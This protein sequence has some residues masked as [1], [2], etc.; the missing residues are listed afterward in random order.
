MQHATKQSLLWNDIDRKFY[1]G[2]YEAFKDERYL[3]LYYRALEAAIT[4]RGTL[5]RHYKKRGL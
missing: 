4:R 2:L 3:K 1:K 5:C